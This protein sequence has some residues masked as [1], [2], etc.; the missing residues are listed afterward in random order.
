MAT[1][2]NK[3]RG[4]IKVSNEL[5]ED[6][7]DIISIIFK[8]FRP[9]HIAFHFWD[10]NTWHIHGVSELFEEVEEGCVVPQYDVIFTTHQNEGDFSVYHTFEFKKV[11]Y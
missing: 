9:I 5:Y 7:Y 11:Q 2:N 8:D 1:G 10:N 6:E 4:L 3:K